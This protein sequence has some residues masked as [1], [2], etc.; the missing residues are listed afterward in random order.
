MEDKLYVGYARRPDFDNPMPGYRY[1]GGR[2]VVAGS[3]EEAIKKLVDYMK[4]ISKWDN[5]EVPRTNIKE[6]TAAQ[7][8]PLEKRIEI[9]E[10]AID[11]A[12]R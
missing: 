12:I 1:D 8:L 4:G 2:V 6:I 7:D 11:K 3:K 10:Q 9:L 5:W